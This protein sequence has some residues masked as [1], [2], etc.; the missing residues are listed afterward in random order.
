ML[1][2]YDKAKAN[3]ELK[4]IINDY[5]KAYE[6]IK[7]INYAQYKAELKPGQTVQSNINFSSDN[8][9]RLKEKAAACREKA[10][11]VIKP[12]LDRIDREITD[13][14]STEATNTIQLLALRSNITEADVENLMKRYG[15]NIQAYKAIRDIAKGKEIDIYKPHPAEEE[16]DRVNNLLHNFQKNPEGYND[17]K[18]GVTYISFM[19]ADIDNTFPTDTE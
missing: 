9:D 14:P 5:R 16:R 7:E 4:Q 11:D 8:V 6:T 19:E 18:S 3:R 15:D 13:A 1:D 17:S 2:K 10:Q 12:L